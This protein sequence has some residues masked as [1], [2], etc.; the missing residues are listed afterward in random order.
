MNV[1]YLNLKKTAKETKTELEK[2]TTVNVQTETAEEKLKQLREAAVSSAEGFEVLSRSIR[3]TDKELDGIA[4]SADN[5][6]DALSG[7]SDPNHNFLFIG[8]EA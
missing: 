1:N 7:V 8:V 6:G 2:P 4:A 5:A 3:Q